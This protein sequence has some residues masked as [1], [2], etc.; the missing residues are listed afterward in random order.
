MGHGELATILPHLPHEAGLCARVL[1]NRMPL[2]E[3]VRASFI[4]VSLLLP[5]MGALQLRGSQSWVTRMRGIPG[6]SQSHTRE[7]AWVPE[8]TVPALQGLI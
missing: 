3:V 2:E 5:G 1:F 4:S 7:G 8:A 6:A